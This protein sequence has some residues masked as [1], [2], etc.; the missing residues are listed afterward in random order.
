MRF[1]PQHVVSSALVLIPASLLPVATVLSIALLNGYTAER[2]DASIRATPIEDNATGEAFLAWDT[3]AG[4]VPQSQ[5]DA[6]LAADRGLIAQDIDGLRQDGVGGALI[7]DFERT[8]DAYNA[9]V[10]GGVGQI[11]SGNVN[12]LTTQSLPVLAG[13]RQINALVSSAQAGFQADAARAQTAQLWGGT[14]VIVVAALLLAWLLV[15]SARRHRRAAVL[16]AEADTLRQS[17]ESFRMLF[18]TN[19]HPM[20]VWDM[21]TRQHLAANAAAVDLY[22]YTGDEFLAMQIIDLQ[23]PEDREGGLKRLE[24]VEPGVPFRGRA[25]HL[26]KDGRIIHVEITGRHQEF[27]GRPAFIALAQDLTE[28]M[29]LEEELRHQALYDSLTQLANRTL[30]RD[31]VEHALVSNARSFTPVAVLLLDLDRFKV[32]ND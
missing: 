12:L 29:A 15:R 13:Y 30:F 25:R 1:S 24:H 20:W 31:R 18:E 4:H 16:R 9:A 8:T 10:V 7:A 23:P 19:P 6:A 14:G 21:S 2:L 32:V 28:R 3:L 17:E 22:G 26:L 11:A 5:L 27:N